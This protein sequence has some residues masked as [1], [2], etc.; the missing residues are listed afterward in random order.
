MG[1]VTVGGPGKKIVKIQLLE[2]IKNKIA[3]AEKNR[4]LNLFQRT[5]RRSQFQYI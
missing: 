2:G 4:F 3:G 1:P 5:W